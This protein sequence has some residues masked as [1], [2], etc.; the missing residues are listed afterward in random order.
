MA[1]VLLLLCVELIMGINYS[2]QFTSAPATEVHVDSSYSYVVAVSDLNWQDSLTISSAKS[3][4]GWLS[5]TTSEGS[6]TTFA[7]SASVAGAIDG[8]A[9][10]A[11][12]D[13]LRGGALDSEGNLYVAD[14]GNR[15]IRKITPAGVVTTFAGTA[16]VTGSADG[17]GAAAQFNSPWRIAI[18]ADDNLYVTEYDNHT[19]RKITPAGVVT[20]VAGSPGVAGSTD[21]TG[22]AALFSNPSGIAITSDGNIYIADETNN[23]IRKMTPAAVVTTFAGNNIGFQDGTGIA[24]KFNFPTAIAADAGDNL[25]VAD[26]L[27]HSIRKITPAAVVTTLAGDGTEG[28]ADGV[29]A[30][31]QFAFPSGIAPEGSD[32][33]ITD[34]TNNTIRKITS[35]GVVTTIAGAVG[36][37]DTTDGIGGAARFNT[38][39]DIVNAGGGAFYITEPVNFTIRKMSNITVL[40]GTPDSLDGALYDIVLEVT[41]NVITTPVQQAF[42]IHAYWDNKTPL[43]ADSG[44]TLLEDLFHLFRHNEFPFSDTNLLDTLNK[45]MVT[46]LPTAGDLYVDADLSFT[47]DSAELVTL[48]QEILK[49]DLSKLIYQPE[50]DSNGTPYNS[51]QFRVSDGAVYSD[52][53]YTM[54]L[55]VN[56]VNDIPVIT[57]TPT[58]VLN[59]NTIYTYW[60]RTIDGG[61]GDN[62]TITTESDLP[63]WL[64]LSEARD[65]TTFVGTPGVSG[66]ADGPGL[67]TLLYSPCGVAVT[68]TG[69]VYISD[70]YNHLIRKVDPFGNVT[71]FAGQEGSA[72]FTDGCGTAAQFNT[73]MGLTVDIEGNVYVA[74]YEN[75]AIRKITP[76]GCVST[77]AGTGTEGYSDGEYAEFG[78]PCGVVADDSGNVYVAD[79]ANNTIRQITADGEVSTI[80]G[81]PGNTGNADGTG[82]NAQF[83]TPMG[84]ALDTNG[85][86]Y[87]AD[88]NNG[89]IREIATD[90]TVS[91]LQDSTGADVTLDG[92]MG[93]A[94]DEEGNIYVTEITNVVTEI[95]NEGGVSVFV[96]TPGVSGTS[97]G[98]GADAE[99]SGLG[100]LAVGPGGFI[101]IIDKNSHCLKRATPE[102]GLWGVP[103]EDEVGDYQIVLEITDGVIDAPV[104]QDFTISVDFVNTTPEARDTT[105]TILENSEHLFKTADFSFTDLNT[106]QAL[107]KIEITAMTGEGTF[108]VDRD[109]DGTV[110]IEEHVA[111]NSEIPAADIALLKFQP[112]PDSNGLAYSSCDFRV[113][114]DLSYSDSSYTITINVT[115]V[116]DAP[117]IE[118]AGDTATM[119]DTPLILLK[120]MFT[121]TDIDNSY[122]ELTISVVEGTNCTFSGTAVTPDLNFF[123]DM[124]FKVEVSDGELTDTVNC[125]VPVAPVNDAPMIVFPGDTAISEDSLFTFIKSMFTLTD[126]DNLYEELTISVVGGTNCT[127][128]ESTITPASDYFG[129]ITISVEVSD[130]LLTDTVVI[131]LTVT[132]VN[133]APTCSGVTA[134]EMIENDSLLI[135]IEMIT[136]AFD[137]DGDSLW[138][139]PIAG[140]CWSVFG[141]Y[142]IPLENYFGQCQIPVQVCDGYLY[143]DTVFMELT[144]IEANEPP[145]LSEIITFP[146]IENESLIVTIEDVLVEDEDEDDVHQLIIEEGNN[147]TVVDSV[148]IPDAGFNG[149]IEVPFVV[150]DGEDSSAVVV[151]VIEVRPVDENTPPVL[152]LIELPPIEK[153]DFMT[154]LTGGVADEVDNFNGVGKK[155]GNDDGDN[156][157]YVLDI[158]D[159]DGDEVRVILGEGDNYT[160]DGATIIPDEDF[161]GDLIIPVSVTDGVSTSEVQYV[162]LEVYR[163]IIDFKKG[164][165]LIE[166][167]GAKV[168]KADLARASE[169]LYLSI[170]AE[171]GENDRLA[172]QIFDPVGNIVST[173]SARLEGEMFEYRWYFS[174]DSQERGGSYVA[175]LTFF[176]NGVK[177]A[178]QKKMVGIQR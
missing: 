170:W 14:Y 50:P 39:F 144:V 22:S 85:T 103:N 72:G 129:N 7:G 79:K 171:A 32:L 151:E 31:A 42:R 127:F 92:P 108:Y 158:F 63:S 100:G 176:R 134:Q 24:A 9:A 140:E 64:N 71:T 128:T 163:K 73:P 88:M 27:N 164:Q 177:T 87:V 3:I 112:E 56:P 38:P 113:H 19:I 20:T 165:V 84:I 17:T 174:H 25:Y 15:V 153:N 141:S 37:S 5:L 34:G 166:K 33:Y 125:T 169:D 99:F 150:T 13:S 105:I 116:N 54:S 67:T 138:V 121:L 62:I 131:P 82:P 11:R 147:Y 74:D 53:S 61:D 98:V 8:I 78:F 122:E 167:G 10:E 68:A 29:G 47:M 102:S 55:N 60:I 80:A 28:S 155:G 139:V 162:K 149:E 49:A 12:F 143:S 83:D 51:F 135:T 69:I 36:T 96:G 160:T 59:M 81:T 4:P 97:D 26:Y 119:E 178:Q 110:D 161:T 130:S 159:A 136:D 70:S 48:N 117:A 123:G 76:E 43:S 94:V 157:E 175:F 132:P 75:H 168:V 104:E 115:P 95:T 58:T 18:D 2:P 109:G 35:A 41:D 23:R 86:L 137:I 114:D 156:Y 106:A 111:P 91:T 16:G 66:Y 40:T 77:L 146:I 118:C 65:V 45:I 6:I 46:A 148:I 1:V 145:I 93:I 133:D 124:T 154:L 52:N 101:F 142:V 89:T 90:G 126:V 57:S 152:A 172:V 44:V 21:G 173:G 120:S 30:A 107:S